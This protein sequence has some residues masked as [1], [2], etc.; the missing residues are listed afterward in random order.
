M[1][2]SNIFSVVFA[3][4]IAGVIYL[5]SLSIEIVG[6]DFYSY[7]NALESGVLQF[8][9]REIVSWWLI[10]LFISSYHDLLILSIILQ[11]LLCYTLISFSIRQFKVGESFDKRVIIFFTL[12]SMLLLNPFNYL[13]SISALRQGIAA[14]FFIVALDRLFRKTLL[15]ALP[16]FILS[17]L[18]H[19]SM[20]VFASAFIFFRYFEFIKEELKLVL[21]VVPLIYV[22]INFWGKQEL[23]TDSN[24]HLYLMSHLLVIGYAIYARSRKLKKI[25]FAAIAPSLGFINELSYFDRMSLFS[26]ALV[27]PVV[28]T[29]LY[30]RMRPQLL[31]IVLVLPF[32]FVFVF[33]MSR[34]ETVW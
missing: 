26:T 1:R 34:L 3:S 23:V 12:S 16:Y 10:S 29:E 32:A 13:L 21:Y 25:V 15:H 33:V 11:L 8:M 19:N 24:R 31:I 7:T 17:I 14:V 28:I 9:Y 18:S 27:W 22:Q 4:M 6:P 5:F 30:S 2:K 20:L